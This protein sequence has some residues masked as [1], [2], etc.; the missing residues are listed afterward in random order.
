[1]S[2]G[3]LYSCGF[4]SYQLSTDTLLEY[5]TTTEENEIIMFEVDGESR[6]LNSLFIENTG[7]SVLYVKPY[8]S[9]YVMTIPSGSSVSYDFTKCTGIQILGSAGQTLRWSGMYF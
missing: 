1:M 5:Y 7:D 3:N 6:N 2:I 9:D 8:E 4:I